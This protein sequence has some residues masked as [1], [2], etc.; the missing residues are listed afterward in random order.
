MTDPS[1]FVL[2]ICFDGGPITAFADDEETRD[3]LAD[4]MADDAKLYQVWTGSVSGAQLQDRTAAFAEAW[5]ACSTSSA[6]MIQTSSF[7]PSRPS[8]WRTSATS[9]LR[10]TAPLKRLRRWL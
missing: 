6:A 3:F 2:V 8:F 9:S 10:P 7:R 4:V 5:G 1:P